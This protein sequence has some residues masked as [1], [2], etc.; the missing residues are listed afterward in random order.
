MA[1]TVVQQ[2]TVRQAGERIVQRL[3]RELRFHP[4]A[5][6]GFRHVPLRDGKAHFQQAQFEGLGDIVVGTGGQHRGEILGTVTRG[7]DENHRLIAIVHRPHATA[8]LK[9][10]DPRQEPIDHHEREGFALAGFPGVLSVWQAN[11]VVPAVRDHVA[12]RRANPIIVV[13]DEHSH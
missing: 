12:Y 7:H 3:V 5:V 8:K 10:V 2:G 13:Y 9:P 1:E 11:H 6:D 4:L